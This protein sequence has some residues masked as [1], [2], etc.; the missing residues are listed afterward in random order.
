MAQ[1]RG[2]RGLGSVYFEASM[3]L[4]AAQVELVTA[5]GKRARRRLRA[6][7]RAEV[8]AKMRRLQADPEAPARL[9]AA[10]PPAHMTTGEWLRFWA[11]NVLPGTVKAS[12]L[13]QYRQVV[14]DWVMPYVGKEP[15]D[16]LRPEHVDKMVRELADAGR[17]VNTQRLART[18][19]RRS[20]TVAERYG[21]V[22]R[23]VAALTD[24]PKGE[25]YHVD[26]LTPDE[27]G[28]VVR[29]AAGDRLE[30][31]AVVV[32]FLGLRQA[33]AL[34][35]RWADVGLDK[36][37]LTVRGTKTEA[38]ARVVPMPASVVEALRRH[39]AAQR[40]ERM[41]ARYWADAELVFPSTIGTRY[42]KRAIT[43]WWHGLTV[44]A[45]V[46][47]RRFHASRH[48]AATLMLNAG[49]PLEVV[50]GILGH[51]SYAITSDVYAKPGRAMLRQAADAMERVLG[52]AQGGVSGAS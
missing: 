8:M 17:A 23:N 37:E 31:L 11:D 4:W 26:P 27:A 50:S 33:E 24:P 41:A 1:R 6:K 22:T 12:T 13:A 43:R 14:R 36:A 16:R 2:A 44:R 49:V 45:G 40:A 20:L 30:A 28:A 19:L 52:P 35:L 46:G 34:D 29:A 18:V 15:L 42:D 5:D 7:T 25:V 21:H 48:T 10:V 51:A 9:G 32:L 3:G 38:S 39:R 47:R